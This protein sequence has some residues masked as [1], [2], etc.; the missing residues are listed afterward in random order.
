MGMALGTGIG[1]NPLPLAGGVARLANSFASRSGVGMQRGWSTHPAA[2][3]QQ[4]AKLPRP[5]P[6][7]GEG[8]YAALRIFASFFSTISRFSRDR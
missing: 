6:L 2:P 8:F 7:S 3:R 1:F 5:S 4:A